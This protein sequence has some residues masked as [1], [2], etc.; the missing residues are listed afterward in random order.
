VATLKNG[1]V[2]HMQYSCLYGGDFW[3]LSLEYSG[4]IKLGEMLVL[5]DYVAF[6]EEY[7]ASFYSYGG[8]YAEIKKARSAIAWSW[9]GSGILLWTFEDLDTDSLR[10]AYAYTD[11][12]GREWG[13][14]MYL[15]GSRNIWFCLSDP[16]NRDIPAF[17]PM[18][19]PSVWES[20]TPHID[21]RQYLDE[22]ENETSTII[23]II[24]SV[25]VL[26]AGTAI[27][28]QVIWKPNKKNGKRGE[29][30]EVQ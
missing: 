1:T 26:V 13:F 17:H 25:V 10:A 12:E 4:W 19:E 24:V 5:Y 6:E 15:Y 9:P 18:P 20:E 3:G 21:I 29:K 2:V 11:A 30:G 23:L 14:V 8:D 22:Q 7:R 16:L 27:L 28:I